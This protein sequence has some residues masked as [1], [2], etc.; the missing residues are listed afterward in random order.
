MDIL[1]TCAR[2]GTP[3][4]HERSASGLP[5]TYCGVLCERAD[6]G[7]NVLSEIERYI[8]RQPKKKEA[9]V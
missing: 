7:G 1:L 3:Y 5:L 2:C 8:L 6:L 4:H 9:V